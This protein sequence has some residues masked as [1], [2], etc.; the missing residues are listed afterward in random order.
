MAWLSDEEYIY[1]QDIKEKKAAG[2][3]IYSKK[4]G[5]KSKKCTL[6]SDYMTRKE[7]MA[8]NGEVMVYNPNTWYS[9]EEFKKL[10]MEYQIKYVNSLLLRYD[11]GLKAI[12]EIL[13]G[14][15]GPSLYN[16][17]KRKGQ[18]Q[19]L[20][21]TGA[22]GGH[23]HDIG[24]KKLEADVL[25]TKKS[26]ILAA[27]DLKSTEEI[28][29]GSKSSGFEIT[30]VSGGSS[31]NEEPKEPTIQEKIKQ[32][33]DTVELYESKGVLMTPEQIDKIYKEK[34]GMSFAS[35]LE[36][37][38]EPIAVVKSVEESDS[39]VRVAAELTESGKKFFDEH[40]ENMDKP[41]ED[42]TDVQSFSIVMSKLDMGII[43]YVR[44]LFDGKKYIVNLEVKE[45]KE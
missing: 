10:P 4:N 37:T 43:E 45:I 7:K 40:P 35:A 22:K 33:Q 16:Y 41:V 30:L 24:R 34:A 13:F 6:P 25:D 27:R 20:N 38:G 31:F 42:S 11:C 39:G 14:I 26:S 23:S 2:R 36:H 44:N 12:G 1:R 15:T 8:M 3:G 17:F 19:Y 29:N 18:Q 21:S 28:Q 5:S 32:A 9:W